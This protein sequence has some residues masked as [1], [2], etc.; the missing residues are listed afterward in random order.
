MPRPKNNCAN[1]YRPTGTSEHCTQYHNHS[2]TIIFPRK[3][4]MYLPHQ[5]R[6]QKGDMI[7]G[8]YG[9]DAYSIN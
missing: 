1:W 5:W 9:G 8:P 2:V 7:S 4:F 6:I 3:I